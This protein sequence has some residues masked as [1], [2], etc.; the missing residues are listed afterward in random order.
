MNVTNTNGISS[1]LQ[2]PENAIDG[3]LF[4]QWSDSNFKNTGVSI[5][6]FDLGAPQQVGALWGLLLE[7]PG[8]AYVYNMYIHISICFIYALVSTSTHAPCLLASR[9]GHLV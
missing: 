5:L 9:P 7:E 1:D 8:D 2:A 4:T 3:D 6:K